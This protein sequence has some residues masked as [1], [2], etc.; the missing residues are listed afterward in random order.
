M[1]A[2][3][4]WSHRA[5]RSSPWAGAGARWPRS[6]SRP[7]SDG[8]ASSW[9]LACR[10]EASREA[11]RPTRRAGRRRGPS[12]AGRRHRASL[13][14]RRGGRAGSGWYLIEIPPVV[15]EKALAVGASAW[16]DELPQLVRAIEEDWELTVGRVYPNSTE[17]LVAEAVCDDGTETV[18]KLMVPRDGEAAAR[19]ATALRLAAGEGCPLLLRDDVA[20]GAL[21]LERL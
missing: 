17:A 12:P 18:L 4:P 14:A 5:T 8:G 19:E 3:S 21:L 15:R 10:S 11:R 9:S 7:G 2:I 1:R 16:I 6:A 13:V 20:R